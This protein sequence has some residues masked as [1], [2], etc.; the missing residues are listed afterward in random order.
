MTLA[1][2]QHAL[3]EHTP[4]RQVWLSVPRDLADGTRVR[5]NFLLHGIRSDG[6]IVFLDGGSVE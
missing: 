6:E 4:N 3:T 2:L 5:V 1:D